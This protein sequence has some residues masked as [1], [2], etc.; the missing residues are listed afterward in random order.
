MPAV[1]KITQEIAEDM[2]SKYESGEATQAELA[3]LFNV[4]IPTV[5]K[6]VKGVKPA[7]RKYRVNPAKAQRDA[8]LV[9][10]YDPDAGVGMKELAQKYEMTHQNVSLI[11]K[12]AGINPQQE[13][14]G[15]LREQSHKRQKRVEALK[16]AKRDAKA[17]KIQELSQLWIGGCTIEQFRE[18]AGLKSANAAQVKIVHLRKK[19]GEEQFPRRNTR[20]SMTQEERDAKIAE[21]SR[22]YQEDPANTAALASVFGEKESSVQRRVCQLRKTLENGEEMFPRRRKA[23]QTVTPTPDTTPVS[24]VAE[25]ETNETENL[26]F[27]AEENEVV[28]EAE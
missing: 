18:A 8:A 7:K 25:E 5:N 11:L 17:A 21:L 16:Q 24:E 22:L 9:A 2:R 19:Y 12:A 6:T 26:E 20:T 10:E 13:Y 23:R 1:K 15:K 3:D 27:V 14:F 4:S 28:T